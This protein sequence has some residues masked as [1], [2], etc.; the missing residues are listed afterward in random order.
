MKPPLSRADEFN[1]LSIVMSCLILLRL[2]FIFKGCLLLLALSLSPLTGNI[3]QNYPVRSL[4]LA[5]LT[6]YCRHVS[7]VFRLKVFPIGECQAT[8]GWPR[9]VQ[10]LNLSSWKFQF[11][12]FFCLFVCFYVFSG[13]AFDLQ[14]LI[15][16]RK[17]KFIMNEALH[18]PSSNSLVAAVS[19]VRIN[20]L[21]LVFSSL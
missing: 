12:L 6:G 19:F 13:S 14:W 2:I 11:H 15:I 4:S 1:F 18:G 20:L 7:R 21:S 5:N 10:L 16:S 9:E 17:L 3:F 8:K